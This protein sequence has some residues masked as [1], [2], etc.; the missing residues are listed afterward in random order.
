MAQAVVD[1]AQRQALQDK[2]NTIMG[3]I[4]AEHSSV[5]SIG[6]CA[7]PINNNILDNYPERLTCN[8]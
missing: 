6:S 1:L 2:W 8:M 3:P 7:L 5:P 4:S